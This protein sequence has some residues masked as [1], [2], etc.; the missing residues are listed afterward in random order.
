MKMPPIVS[1]QE[2]QDAREELLVKEKELTRARDAL[3]AERR[4][5]PRMAVE[6]EYRFEGPDGPVEPARPVRGA[7]PADRLPLLLRT[8]RR[9]LA[10]ERLPRLLVDG[11]PGRPPRPPQRARHHA[12]STS[13]G[14]RRRRSSASRRGWA[15]RSPG[16]RS[17]TTSTPTSGSTNGTGPTSSSAT[18]RTGSSAPTSSTSAAT[19][20]LGSTWAYLDITPLGR[21]EK[22]EDSPEGYPQTQPYAW[23]NR[24]DEYDEATVF[25]AALD[26]ATASQ[27]GSAEPGAMIVYAHVAGMP[28]EE[29]LPSLAGPATGLVMARAWLAVNLRRGKDRHR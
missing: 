28:V 9:R 15:G 7:P 17:P 26:P 21:Q 23:W 22:W 20:T 3:A 13:R 19:S 8:R 29:L 27:R 6:K 25:E 10:R 12:A 18:T 4:R 2:W 14:R 11:R 16:T 5:M 24:H 1:P